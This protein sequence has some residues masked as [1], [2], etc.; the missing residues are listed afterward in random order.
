MTYS[1][2]AQQV[3]RAE[4]ERQAYWTGIRSNILEYER[5]R[6]ES[7]QNAVNVLG[8]DQLRPMTKEE[9]SVHNQQASLMNIA[10]YSTLLSTVANFAEKK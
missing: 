5:R 1:D 3:I 9:I 8:R 7:M 10:S 2:F 4:Q 6:L